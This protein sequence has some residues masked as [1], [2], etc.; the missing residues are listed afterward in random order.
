MSSGIIIKKRW[1]TKGI[2]INFRYESRRLNNNAGFDLLSQAPTVQIN[3]DSQQNSYMNHSIANK[4][5]P[6]DRTTE[7]YQESFTIQN[8]K[9]KP[10]HRMKVN[11]L[12]KWLIRGVRVDVLLDRLQRAAD[13]PEKVRAS[14]ASES[15]GH[16]HLHFQRVR[17]DQETV[18]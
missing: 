13:S 3:N 8:Q 16:E 6:Y 15:G 1:S 12:H 5:L 17:A 10:H 9:R 7:G 11:K 2:G 14:I 18:Q 4:Y